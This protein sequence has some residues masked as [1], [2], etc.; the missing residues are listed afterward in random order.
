MEHKI[1]VQAPWGEEESLSLQFGP[2]L[3]SSMSLHTAKHRKFVQIGV[4]GLTGQLLE[5]REPELVTSSSV[6]VTFK[7]LNPVAGQKLG[8]GNGVRVSFMW[9]MEVGKGE[10][11]TGAIKVDFKVK[12]CTVVEG[13]GEGED[14]PLESSKLAKREEVYTYRCNFDVTDYVVSH[15]SLVIIYFFS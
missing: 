11:S 4:T 15:L 13:E 10:K 7:S 6:D 14:D 12:Y 8:I 9:E 3:M 2:P 1:N 5:L